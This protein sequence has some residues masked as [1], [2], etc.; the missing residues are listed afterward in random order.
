LEGSKGRETVNLEELF[1]T[2]GL[3]PSAIEEKK[4]NMYVQHSDIAPSQRKKICATKIGLILKS[5]QL[6][7]YSGDIY[8]GS[9]LVRICERNR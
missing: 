5:E 9:S 1:F 7:L 4:R 6:Q 8:N 3:F 2:T